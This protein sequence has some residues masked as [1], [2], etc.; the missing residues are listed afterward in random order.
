MSVRLH[1]P[2][3]E[4][5]KLGMLIAELPRCREETQALRAQVLEQGT[6]L[7]QLLEEQSGRNTL[8]RAGRWIIGL[9]L[10]AL[11]SGAAAFYAQVRAHEL[12]I[13]RQ[14]DAISTVR[15]AE[16][17]NERAVERTTRDTTGMRGDLSAQSATLSQIQRSLGELRE[18]VRDMRRR[19]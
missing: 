1:P 10:G 17:A 16:E 5:E 19:H 14:S 9:V 15:N 7:D 8:V 6:K 11:I 2:L 12:A 18:D 4:P 13:A 3:L